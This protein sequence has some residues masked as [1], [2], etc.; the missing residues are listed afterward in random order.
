MPTQATRNAPLISFC[1]PHSRFWHVYFRCIKRFDEKKI[2]DKSKHPN[3]YLRWQKY[4]AT[5]TKKCGKESLELGRSVAFILVADWSE[6]QTSDLMIEYP[7]NS[8]PGAQLA[9]AACFGSCS[10]TLFSINTACFTIFKV[11]HYVYITF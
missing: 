3:D 7:K 1:A 8:E 11:K 6:E 9:A 4:T 2:S 5:S 10:K